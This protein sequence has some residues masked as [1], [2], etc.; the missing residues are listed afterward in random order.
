MRWIDTDVMIADP[1]TKAMEPDKLV[2]ALDSNLWDIEQPI[3]SVIKKK[4]KQLARRKLKADDQE[5]EA[6]VDSDD[7]DSHHTGR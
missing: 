1:F 6:E 3:E 2:A 4:A 7:G 5:A